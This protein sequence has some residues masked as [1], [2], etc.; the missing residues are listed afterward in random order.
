MK[1]FLFL[2]GI[3]QV[4]LYAPLYLRA[5]FARYDSGIADFATAMAIDSSSG[6]VYVTS[7]SYRGEQQ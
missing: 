2:S 6:N 5:E 4:I 7:Y 3:F 1:S